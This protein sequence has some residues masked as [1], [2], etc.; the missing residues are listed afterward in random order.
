[1]EKVCLVGASEDT[2]LRLHELVAPREGAPLDA[3]A[4]RADVEA[5]FELGM[6]RDVVAVAQPLPS[7][8]VMLS[9]LVTEYDWIS[10]V[11][12]T[13]ASAVKT[14]ELEQV[15]HAGLKAS[16]FVLR[17]LGEQ[18]KAVYAG[19][20]YT[21]A[22]TVP[23][24]KSASGGNAILTFEIEE[25]PHVTVAAITFEGARQVGDAE[26]RKALLSVVGSSYL[27]DVVQRDTF[28]LTGLYFDHG[29][30]NVAVDVSTRPAARPEGAVELVFKVVEGDLFHLGKLSLS[31]YSL[32]AEKDVLKNVESKPKSVFSRSALQR[33]MERIRERAKQR[34]LVVEVT[35]LTTV[36]AEK[37]IIDVTFELEKKP[38][39]RVVF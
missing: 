31:G 38:G 12:F 36:D 15:A 3:S 29:F 24:L 28:S 30:V 26:L 10:E 11:Y 5:L 23:V 17:S 4:V 39:G 27:E 34:G 9:Y 35:P 14:S 16:P 20:G 8:G 1:V 32:G 33:D 6:L 21:H 19:L 18:V 37:K 25:G 13:G 2:Y 7:K 22:K